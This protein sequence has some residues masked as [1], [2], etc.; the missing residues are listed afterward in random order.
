M[1]TNQ[2]VI[3]QNTFL[4]KSKNSSD[5]AARKDEASTLSLLREGSYTSLQV[6]E[7]ILRT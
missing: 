1:V 2:T 6:K 4:K 3:I 7:K 5:T